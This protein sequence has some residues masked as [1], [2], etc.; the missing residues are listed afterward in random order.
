MAEQAPDLSYDGDVV[1]LL[2]RQHAQI[3]DLFVEVRAT[4]GEERQEAFDRLRRLLAVHETAEEEVVHPA[5]RAA[6]PGGQGVV[7]DRLAEE[8]EAKQLLRQLDELGPD[9]PRF[10][11][12]VD[13][14][15]EA[16]LEHA[17]S[18]ERYEFVQLRRVSEPAQLRAMAGVVQAAEAVA[19]TRPHP[20]A[21]SATANIVAGPFAAVVDRV[22]DAIRGATA[23]SRNQG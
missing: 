7:D 18:E 10:G 21:E 3:R 5:A 22:R 15:R 9:D 17:R 14:L 16:V 6:L 2:V 19:P 20:G 11:E 1:D 23:G 13:Q 4:R 8:N 12:L